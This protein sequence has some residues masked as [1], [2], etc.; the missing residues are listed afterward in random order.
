MARR[1]RQLVP[2]LRQ[3]ELGVQRAWAHAAPHRE[4]QRPSH[5]GLGSQ[6]SLAAGPPPG[7]SP[8]TVRA[9]PLRMTMNSL[10]DFS[11]KTLAGKDLG[12]KDYRG[13]VVLVVN[14]ASECG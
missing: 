8:G 4:H 2:L 12:L 14:T 10:Y 1:R 5:Q 6:V 3:R 13:K 7:R 11:A 9:R